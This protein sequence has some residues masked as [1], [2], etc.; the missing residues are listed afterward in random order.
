MARI[1]F[2]LPYSLFAVHAVALGLRGPWTFLTLGYIFVVI[3]AAD[4][5]CGRTT[6][7]A[8]LAAA[9][10]GFF[11][12]LLELWLPLQAVTIF[13]TMRAVMLAP[14]NALEWVGL[15][16]SL[17]AVTGAG[18]ITVAHELVHRPGKLHRALAE[19][20]MT[21]VGYAHFCI[22]HVHGHHRRVGLQEDPV[23]AR[24]GESLYAFYPRAI[25]R[26][27]VSAWR[28]EEAR[29]QRQGLRAL[30]P[31]DRRLRYPMSFVLLAA[32]VTWGFGALGL[33]LL[34]GQALFAVLLLEAVDYVEHYGLRRRQLESGALERVGEHHSWNSNERLT[35]AFLFHVTRHSDHHMLAS[36]PYDLLRARPSAPS[37]PAGYP[38]MMLLAALPPLWFRVMDPR[39]EEVMAQAGRTA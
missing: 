9:R 22:E 33:G 29:C 12:R 4:A 1:P 23:T 38:T 18:G 14:P 21:S 36:R 7:D 16:T 27:A 6:R 34:L 20:L 13:W 37:L 5:L 35:G 30:D 3:P 19:L 8:D 11:D 10:D 25:L 32:A 31:R 17:G 24:R 28:I 39:A 2:L 26:G 15:C